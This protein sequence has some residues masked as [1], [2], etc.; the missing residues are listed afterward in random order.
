MTVH[1][2]KTRMRSEAR[3]RRGARTNA[4]QRKLASGVT[5]ALGDL[6]ADLGATSVA[7]FLSTSSEPETREAIGALSPR[8]VKVF[9]P[10]SHAEGVMEWTLVDAN[11]PERPG[12]GGMPEPDIGAG[13]TSTS[14][15]V[16][17]VICPAAAVDDTGTRLGWGGGYYDR[18]L[19]ELPGETP[20]FALVFDNDVITDLPREAHDIPVTGVVTP[21]GWRRFTQR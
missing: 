15:S 13:A 8:G 19:A 14:I 3:A 2:L 4:E 7:I 21:S 5:E 10:V 6:I 9:A 18:F 12:P 11:T 20:V 17:V 1:E 16:D